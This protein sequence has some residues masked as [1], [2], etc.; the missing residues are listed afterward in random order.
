MMI[1]QIQALNI[2]QGKDKLCDVCDEADTEVSTHFCLDCKQY[3]CGIHSSAHVRSKTSK[4]HELLT[5]ADYT[6]RVR[7]NDQSS[8][9]RNH[10]SPPFCQV[11]GHESQR[12]DFFCELCEQVICTSCALMDH[13]DHVF[14]GIEDV[15]QRQRS[16]LCEKIQVNKETR[17][18]IANSL[19]NVNSVL[20][21]LE[22]NF[23]NASCD[24]DELMESIVQKMFE[25]K[26]FLMNQLKQIYDEKRSVLLLQKRMLN[27]ALVRIDTS[28]SF[29]R[30]LLEAKDHQRAL[31][32]KRM[33]RLSLE[34]IPR[35]IAQKDMSPCMDDVIIFKRTNESKVMEALETLGRVSKEKPVEKTCIP[36][37]DQS[38]RGQDVLL[39]N[40]DSTMYRTDHR[41]WGGVQGKQVWGTW[42]PSTGQTDDQQVITSGQYRMKLRI[43]SLGNNTFIGI[44]YN[45]ANLNEGP[46]KSEH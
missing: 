42:D 37:W 44:C 4:T 2:L 1:Q 20:Q 7:S 5:V 30:E 11:S 45:D 19:S 35:L 12:S 34:E 15:Y 8:L 9:E 31:D 46:S 43:D 32:M 18:N 10:V 14:G 40:G 29:C 22:T 39:S 36:R 33:V 28:H 38:R 3:L 23:E 41:G 24:A 21:S 26:F 17:S 6:S 25:R 16:E 13:R 27:D